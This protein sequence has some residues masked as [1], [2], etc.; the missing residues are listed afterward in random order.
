M[1][2]LLACPDCAGPLKNEGALLRCPCAAWPVV[3]EIPLLVAWAKNRRFTL[4]EV[5]ARFLPPAEGLVGKIVRRILPAGGALGRAVADRDA[6]FLDLAAALGRGADLDYFRYRFSDL[7]YI[8]SAALLAPLARGPVLDLGCGAGHLTEAVFRR[9]PKSLVVGLDFNFTLLYLAKRFVAPAALF[10]CADASAR[11]PFRDAAFDAAVSADAFKYLADRAGAARELLRVA[12]GP[13][14]IS[15]LGHPTA[16]EPGAAEPLGPAAYLGLFARRAPLLYP[17]DELLDAFLKTRRLDLSRPWG[18]PD[19]VSSLAAGVEPAVY[20]GADYFVRGDRL[21][22][23]YE[24]AEDGERLH[25]RRRF[26]S[27]EFSAAC[28]RAGDVLPE[29]LTITREQIASRDPELVRR[30]VLLELPP[31]YC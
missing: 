26:L 9:I 10:V 7:A 19:R 24:A 27:A 30:F 4:E 8:A 31:N 29:T 2:E 11:L 25:L 22:P 21:N 17:E 18:A 16:R 14:L 1:P 3:A 13:I 23:I 28:A 6:T 15:H 20:P 12:R 5:L